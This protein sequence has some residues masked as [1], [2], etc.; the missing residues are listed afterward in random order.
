MSPVRWPVRS[1]PLTMLRFS[2]GTERL[3]STSHLRAF[4]RTKSGLRVSVSRVLVFVLAATPGAIT[5]A[6]L[7]AQSLGCNHMDTR[8][9]PMAAHVPAEATWNKFLNN[10]EHPKMPKDSKGTRRAEATGTRSPRR[11]WKRCLTA[12][13]VAP[14]RRRARAAMRCSRSHQGRRSQGIMNR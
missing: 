2:R 13:N 1:C 14:T 5:R 8:L 12:P 3:Q 10:V 7:L 6:G 11:R 4:A 9:T